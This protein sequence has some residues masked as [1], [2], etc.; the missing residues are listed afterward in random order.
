M[1]PH[2]NDVSFDEQA[3]LFEARA[4]LTDDVEARIAAAILEYGGVK[5]GDW[6][7]EIGAGTGEIGA[8]LVK[9]PIRYV[10]LDRSAA[11]LDEFRP[12]V[13]GQADA[14]LVTAD[15][16]KPWPIDAG[17]AQ[18]VFGSRVFHLLD[19]AHAVA[20][21][22]RVL[23][24]GGVLVSGRVKRDNAGPKAQT[25]RKMHE[26]LAERGVAPRQTDRLRKKVFEQA[27]ALG[28][29]RLEPLVAASWSV[30]TSAADS[31]E[32][33][34]NKASMGGVTPPAEVKQAVLNDLTQ[35]AA[36]T[37]GAADKQITTQDIYVLEGVR[38]GA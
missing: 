10:G 34:R 1:K 25:R 14:R 8:W 36:A 37:F 24:P 3:R 12:R 11:M 15:A 21:A 33:W 28:G 30:T 6:V 4:G 7:V 19:I 29:T 18:V 22:R 20:E 38:F 17:L 26:L 13:P 16:D 32:G 2:S 23:A 9:Q 31:I 5:P 27:E 35:W